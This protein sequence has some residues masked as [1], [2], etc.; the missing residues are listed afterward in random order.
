MN[1]LTD[2]P[3]TAFIGIGWA[4]KKHDLCLQ[5]GDSEMRE[6]SLLAHRMEDIE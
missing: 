3:F 1:S 2:S 4:D 5:P 6:F